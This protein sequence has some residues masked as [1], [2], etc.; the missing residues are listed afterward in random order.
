M[1]G[2]WK[3]VS[4]SQVALLKSASPFLRPPRE[5]YDGGLP[6]RLARGA[7]ITFDPIWY[8]HHYIDAAME[9]SEGWFEDP[10]H[11]FLEVGRLRGYL[12]TCPVGDGIPLDITLPNLAL[13]KPASQSS[14]SEF[15]IGATPEEDAAYAVN[16]DPSK[17]IGFHTAL[18]PAPWWMV[19]LGEV[20]SIRFIRIFNRDTD[21][22]WVLRRASPLLVEASNDAEQWRTLFCTKAGQL[23]GGYKAGPPLLWSSAAPVEGRFIRVSIPRQEHLHLAEVEV[24]GRCTGESGRC[25]TTAGARR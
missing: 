9:I 20:A 25:S 16:G 23:F 22:E 21:A 1:K 8:A 19:D 10:L 24:Y 12:P 4:R 18:D 14:R 3:E 17:T 13:N 11:H 6:R 7:L 15:S 2:Y 5:T